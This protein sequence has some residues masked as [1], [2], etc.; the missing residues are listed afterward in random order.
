MP[1]VGKIISSHNKKIQNPVEIVETVNPGCNCRANSDPCPMEGGCL[2]NNVVYRATVTDQDDKV[3]TYTGLTGMTFK[4]RYQGHKNSF[5]YRDSQS[6]TTLSSHVWNLKDQSKNFNLKWEVVDK[7]NTFNP[8]SKKC[9]LCLK[10]KYHI[11]FQPDGAS[12]NR[13]SE[14]F[15]TCRHRLRQLLEN[16]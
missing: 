8:I 13:R 7:A 4:K 11:L 14:L 6:S 16:T 15:S 2:V 1:N 9:R 3:E 12:L 10:E 5:K